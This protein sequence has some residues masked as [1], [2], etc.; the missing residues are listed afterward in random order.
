M[1]NISKASEGAEQEGLGALSS[2][3]F[4]ETLIIKTLI[5]T[6]VHTVVKNTGRFHNLRSRL[7]MQMNS[8]PCCVACSNP[9][10]LSYM[11]MALSLHDQALKNKKTVEH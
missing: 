3:A 10:W 7:Y 1:E 8:V 11:K 5:I 2:Y 6:L 9:T 4:S